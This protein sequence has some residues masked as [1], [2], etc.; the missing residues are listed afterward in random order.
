[1][2]DTRTF[3]AVVIGLACQAAFAQPADRQGPPR[4]VQGQRMQQPERGKHQGNARGGDRKLAKRHALK[5]WLKHHPEARRR[6]M[7]H[8][9]RARGPQGPDQGFQGGPRG[10]GAGPGPRGGQGG[11]QG[12]PWWRN[13]PQGPQGGQDMGPRNFN[14]PQG[15]MQGRGR[16]GFGQGGGFGPGAFPGGPNFQRGNQGPAGPDQAGPG[17]GGNA[18][19]RNFGGF[20]RG[21]GPDQRP[22]AQRP[23]GPVGE[24]DDEGPAD[25]NRMEQ[26]RPMD[27]GNE[28]EQD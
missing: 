14:G 13:G 8:M 1:M 24:F 17:A 21:Q 25:Q 3:V 20:G 12:G 7:E 11:P 23:R 9:G 22:R 19:P 10:Q 16:Q 15:P 26:K 28:R 4:E 2:L 6:L 5:Q 18:G 27:R